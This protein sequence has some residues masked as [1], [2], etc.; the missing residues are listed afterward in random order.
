MNLTADKTDKYQCKIINLNH[1][2]TPVR[3]TLRNQITSGKRDVIPH[4][5]PVC[6][7]KASSVSTIYLSNER[8]VS[9]IIDKLKGGEN[10]IIQ[11]TAA[12]VNEQ[13]RMIDCISGACYMLHCTISSINSNIFY[14]STAWD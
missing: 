2:R 9:E 1:Y 4:F 13:Q 3:T 14:V 5:R 8:Q 11:F 7:Q 6:S 10:V 12:D